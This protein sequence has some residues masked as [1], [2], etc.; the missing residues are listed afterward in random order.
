MTLL[1]I[2]EDYTNR[3]DQ[4]T[5]RIAELATELTETKSQLTALQEYKT[6][7]EDQVST[8]LA[9]GDPAQF[10]ALAVEFL[11]PAVEKLRLERIA[12]IEALKAETAALEAL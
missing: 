9:S 11:V 5:A 2:A 1:Q 8:V 3:F 10:A 6:S 12:K 7:M 4:A